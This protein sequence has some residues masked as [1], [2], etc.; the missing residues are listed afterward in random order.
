MLWVFLSLHKRQKKNTGIFLSFAFDVQLVVSCCC[1]RMLG[2][3][4]SRGVDD[5]KIIASYAS[6][7]S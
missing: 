1:L 3:E 7:K 2:A 6:S 5:D 4:S